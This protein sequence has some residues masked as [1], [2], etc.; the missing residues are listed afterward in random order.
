MPK[1]HIGTA[2]HVFNNLTVQLPCLF[3]TCTTDF[4][5]KCDSIVYLTSSW[6]K[7]TEVCC[8][9]FSGVHLNGVL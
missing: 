7:V 6:S 2:L 8:S 4:C 3:I 5:F 1:S 9:L